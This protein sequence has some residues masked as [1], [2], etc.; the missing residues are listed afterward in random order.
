MSASSK[1]KR[2]SFNWRYWNIV[3]HR[4]VGYLLAV[5][6]I[7]YA[8]S[9][10]A[11]NH[12]NDWNPNYTFERV[13][14]RFEPFPV[15]DRKTMV[16]LAV[17]RLGLPELPKESFRSSPEVIELY[18]KDWSAEVFATEGRAVVERPNDRFLLRDFNF[19]HLNHGK[20]LWTFV[21]DL[22]AGLLAFLAISGI[23]MLKGKKGLAGRGKW[24][25][26]AGL[27]VPLVFVI[28]LRYL[29]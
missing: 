1:K 23:I 18:Y 4:D 9:G 5:L 12:I 26:L 3:L 22:Y 16:A 25:V 28:V 2:R 7:I 15:S 11:V 29:G 27:A 19:L 10:I 17:E 21:A 14:Q 8:V 24:F 20:G 13:E 6:T